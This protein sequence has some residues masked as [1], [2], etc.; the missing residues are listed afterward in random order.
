VGP[1][2]TDF[3]PER[4]RRDPYAAYA[5]LREGEP[6]SFSESLDAFVLARYRDAVSVLQDRRWGNDHRHRTGHEE[7]ASEREREIGLPDPAGRVLL[8][9]DAPDHTRLRNL[10]R[11]AFTP[12]MVSRLSARVEELVDELLARGEERGE[13]ELMS[14]FAYPL[15]VTVI[16]EM[17]GVPTEDVPLF[18]EGSRNLIGLLD[19]DPPV[20]KL[21][22]AAEALFQFA[23]YLVGLL[24]RRRSEPRHDLIT[25]LLAA[26]E[27]GDVLEHEELISLCIL[28]FVAGH[29][30]TMNLIGNGM[31]A[32]L[33]NR[34]QLERLR[35]DPSL[36]RSAVEELLRYDSPVQLTVRTALEDLDVG[37]VTVPK[38]QQVVV[39]LGS[40]NRDPDAFAEPDVLDLARADNHHLSFGH[41]SHFCL[42]ASLA[43]LE[44]RIAFTALA[45]RFSRIEPQIDEPEWRD[46]TTLR[47][48]K[49]LP[50][51]LSPY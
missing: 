20:E 26:E 49:E 48:L 7:W 41:G 47:G 51:A 37:G 34:D 1:T 25:A 17:L 31:W 19:L 5:R 44:G 50:L 14:D 35:A 15:P 9:M 43:R 8:F 24:E 29:E 42:G 6:V 13:I 18:R 28:L 40:A 30:T 38:G 3:H 11:K 4:V 45:R 16:A 27:S 10:A 33:G 22:A 21:R 46:T 32:L 23:V 39:L 2:L 36:G 12:A